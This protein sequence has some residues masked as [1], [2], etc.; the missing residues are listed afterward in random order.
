MTD[1]TNEAD[2][3][4]VDARSAGAGVLHVLAPAPFGGL[5]RVVLALAGGQR[6]RGGR[7]TAAALLS[8][9]SNPPVLEELRVAGVDVRRIV[10]RSRSYATQIQRLADIASEVRP[11][12]IHSHGYLADVL[13]GLM[14]RQ[15]P[16]ARATTVHGFTGGDWKNRLYQWLQ[17]RAHRRFDAVVAVSDLIRTR[18]VQAGIASDRV[19]VVRNALPPMVTAHSSTTARTTLDIPSDAFS[20]GW[21][22][23]LSREKGLDVLIDALSFLR[24]LP[25]HLTVVGDGPERPG[26]ES[27]ARERRVSDRIKFAGVVSESGRLMNGFDV[28]VLSSRTE[29][30]P[31]TL[32]EAMHSS[33]PIVATSVGGIPQVI[34][35]LEGV[36][37]PPERP[38]SLALALRHVHAEPLLATERARRALERLETHFA[39]DAWIDAYERIYRQAPH[40]S[41]RLAS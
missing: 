21:V 6:A 7:V 32:L 9:D 27:L 14:R 26:L 36:L 30:T 22:G 4:G 15:V 12:V 3:S 40:S 10:T 16:F 39:R 5:E 41:N 20:I 19:H 24:D 34:T 28:L 1:H 25:F 17:M 31:I 8:P 23:R 18:L 37:V 29:G 35:P 11:A 13:V 2:P 33:V 38:D